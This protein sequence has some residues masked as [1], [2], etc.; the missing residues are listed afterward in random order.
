MCKFVKNTFKKTFACICAAAITLTMIPANSLGEYSPA[1]EAEA[2]GSN[3]YVANLQEILG[4]SV[5]LDKAIDKKDEDNSKNAAYGFYEKYGNAIIFD[6]ETNAFYYASGS[7][8]ATSSKTFRTVGYELKITIGDSTYYVDVLRKPDDGKN[9][10]G[11]YSLEAVTEYKNSSDGKTYNLFRV[12]MNELNEIFDIRKLDFATLFY[13][14]RS[15]LEIIGD[16]YLIN[17]TSG[18]QDAWVK[19]TDGD[20]TIDT[21]G[22][23]GVIVDNIEDVGKLNISSLE[24]SKNNYY[25]KIMRLKPNAYTVETDRV[26]LTTASTSGA[27]YPANNSNTYYYINGNV[28]SNN[29]YNVTFTG[30]SKKSKK[31]AEVDEANDFDLTQGRLDVTL[32][33][34]LDKFNKA[35]DDYNNSSNSNKSGYAIMS[36]SNSKISNGTFCI[37]APIENNT[38]NGITYP[39][40]KETPQTS[41]SSGATIFSSASGYSIKTYATDSRTSNLDVTGAFKVKNKID[42]DAVIA[43]TPFVKAVK[44]SSNTSSSGIE[45]AR[46]EA[47]KALYLV[48]DTTAPVRSNNKVETVTENGVVYCR[49]KIKDTGSGIQKAVCNGSD[50]PILGGNG[51]TDSYGIT[52]NTTAYVYIDTTNLSIG[53]KLY[54]TLIDNVGNENTVSVSI[55]GNGLRYW[56]RGNHVESQFIITSDAASTFTM[57]AALARKYWTFSGWKFLDGNHLGSIALPNEQ[58]AISGINNV[59]AQW[60]PN[61]YTVIFHS[62]APAS[63]ST[64]ALGVIEGQT[65]FDRTVAKTV[66]FTQNGNVSC[67]ASLPGYTFQGWYG[68]T[69]CTVNHFGNEMDYTETG[70]ECGIEPDANGEIHL[71]AKWEPIDIGVKFDLNKPTNGVNHTLTSSN[72]P[73]FT[74]GSNY[75]VAKFDSV[76]TGVPTAQLTGWHDASTDADTVVNWFQNS[77]RSNTGAC[78]SEGSKLDYSLVGNPNVTGNIITVYAQWD[79]NTYAIYYISNAPKNASTTDES[80]WG[81]SQE[82]QMMTYDVPANLTALDLTTPSQ[83]H[84]T[85]VLPGYTWKHWTLDNGKTYQN[86]AYVQNLTTTNHG[87]IALYAQWT[88]NTYT[89]YYNANKPTAKNNTHAS[90]STPI[91]KYGNKSSIDCIPINIVWDSKFEG[92]VPTATLTGWHARYDADDVTGAW[93]T[94]SDYKEP[95]NRIDNAGT[96]DYKTVGYPDDKDL[97][98]QWQANWYYVTYDGNAGD[99]VLTGNITGAR[100]LETQ[101][102]ELKKYMTEYAYTYTFDRC[103]QSNMKNKENT[104]I[105]IYDV[106]MN[107]AGNNFTKYDDGIPEVIEIHTDNNHRTQKAS[108][109]EKNY[110]CYDLLGVNVSLVNPYEKYNTL[111]DYDFLGWDLGKAYTESRRHNWSYDED[112]AVKN[113]TTE[114]RGALNM[115]AFWNA[116]PNFTTNGDTRHFEVYEGADITMESLRNRVKLYDKEEKTSLKCSIKQIRY[117]DGTTVDNPAEDYVLDTSKVF[118]TY[119]VTFEVT[120]GRGDVTEFACEGEINYNKPPTLSSPPDRMKYL[121]DIRSLDPDNLKRPEWDLQDELLLPVRKYDLLQ[122]EEDDAYNNH[123]ELHTDDLYD[124]RID[125]HLAATTINDNDWNVKVADGK[126]WQTTAEE[127]DRLNRTLYEE[128]ALNWTTDEQDF[129]KVVKYGYGYYDCFKKQTYDV[130]DKG[131]EMIDTE[132]DDADPN[133]APRKRVRFVELDLLWTLEGTEWD[134]NTTKKGR[135]LKEILEAMENGTAETKYRFRSQVEEDGERHVYQWIDGEWVPYDTTIDYSYDVEDPY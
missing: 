36:M 43:I 32:K 75:I 74:S 40:S 61:T 13:S 68:N 56:D 50:L 130:S 12:S 105:Y 109:T 42:D 5:S 134:P 18:K 107:T 45:S 10:K 92:N 114:H 70:I 98:A 46:N 93:Y 8:T 20:G 121:N 23:T 122:D 117:E 82:P 123:E 91:V 71:Y 131:I 28:N 27:Y 100:N 31:A 11:R 24:Q 62:N 126:M 26:K 84:N 55:P 63:C 96:F 15:E 86:Q 34:E 1:I 83:G 51:A 115:Y 44:D 47:K 64:T 17:C 37:Y 125:P 118:Q 48:S 58:W 52:R 54:I 65:G 7:K 60:T 14:S 2:A 104:L 101:C 116:F 94:G 9:I 88:P 112:S 110:G 3:G 21:T 85:D 35:L 128:L 133:C 81:W 127:W 97:Y 119:T 67:S 25:G 87:S 108:Y 69:E 57:R 49:F 41:Y 80:I 66:Q 103:V 99:S 6:Q 102:G 89:V 129:G 30:T 95:G 59:D 79:P 73:Y 72:S 76:I 4:V 16:A 111:Y 124:G 106:E 132:H 90:T 39:T 53:D 38:A 113:L 19:D 135:E 22:G 120:D 29:V 77:A 78:L 33:S